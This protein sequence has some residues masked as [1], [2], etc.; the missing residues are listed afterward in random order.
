MKLKIIFVVSL[1]FI[2]SLFVG[3]SPVT[4]VHIDDGQTVNNVT[5]QLNGY[6]IEIKNGINTWYL[7]YSGYVDESMILIT[8]TDNYRVQKPIIIHAKDGKFICR[9]NGYITTLSNIKFNLDDSMTCDIVAV[10][11]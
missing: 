5:T 11:E 7:L 4:S 1:L 10:K 9:C 2:C 3:C 8:M 6:I